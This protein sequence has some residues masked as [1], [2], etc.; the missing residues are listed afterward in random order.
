MDNTCEINCSLGFLLSF[1]SAYIRFKK[2]FA[3][4]SVK[5]LIDSMVL[6]FEKLSSFVSITTPPY[7]S[8]IY[9]SYTTLCMRCFQAKSLNLDSSLIST[10]YP[11]LP[12]LHQHT[13]ELHVNGNVTHVVHLHD[14]N[15]IQ[16][17]SHLVYN[18]GPNI[19]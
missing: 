1:K 7:L 14:H 5:L 4:F 12:L 17:Y 18:S 19:T 10:E 6:S 2:V 15:S 13:E 8:I 3:S 11:F 16:H 9:S